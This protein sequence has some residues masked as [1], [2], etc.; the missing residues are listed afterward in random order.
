MARLHLVRDAWEV[1][2]RRLSGR[3]AK[4]PGG[5]GLTRFGHRLVLRDL[6]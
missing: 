1:R 4:A 5:P 6:S 2:L 3:V